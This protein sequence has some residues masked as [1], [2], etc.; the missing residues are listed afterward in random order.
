MCR[1]PEIIRETQNFPD[2][3]NTANEYY[4]FI[5]LRSTF[6]PQKVFTHV[7][8]SRQFMA[9]TSRIS[10]YSLTVTNLLGISNELYTLT[11]NDFCFV[12]FQFH[13]S[14]MFTTAPAISIT[15]FQQHKLKKILYV[16]HIHYNMNIKHIQYLLR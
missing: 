2:H 9:K 4:A 15:C 8:S 7:I 11:V 3:N 5:V 10:K 14:R 12:V 6:R 13:C 1:F 16:L